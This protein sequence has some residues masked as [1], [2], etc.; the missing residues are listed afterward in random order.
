[1]PRP[2]TGAA[3]QARFVRQ[4]EG[5]V[6][7]REVTLRTELDKT[8]AQ[9]SSLQGALGDKPDYGLGEGDP[10]ITRR[11]LDRALLEQFKERAAGIEQALS[12]MAEDEYGVCEECGQP[13]HPDRLAVLPDARTCVRCARARESERVGQLLR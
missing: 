13:I 4:G 7:D 8:Q 2:V 6:G 1:M 5:L 3:C 10:A 11:E 9:I 12:A